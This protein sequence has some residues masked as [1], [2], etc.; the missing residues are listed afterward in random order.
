MEVFASN[1]S[2]IEPSEVDSVIERLAVITNNATTGGSTTFAEDLATT[3]NI[4]NSTVEYL[5]NRVSSADST[6]LL[7]FNEVCKLNVLPQ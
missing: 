3:N 5:L 4:I 6:S 7:E 2:D 1:F